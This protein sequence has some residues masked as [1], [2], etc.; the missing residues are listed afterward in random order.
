MTNKVYPKTFMWLFIGLALTF[1]TG[2]LV[3][4]N[5]DMIRGVVANW[6]LL[7][8]IELG[9][10]IFLGARITKM[11]YL[12]AIITYLLYSFLTGLTFSV[13]FVAFTISSIM[14]IFAVTAI[15]FLIFAAIGYFTKLDITKWSSMLLMALLGLIIMIIIN[16]FF[17]NSTLDLII[18]C[19]G[20]LIFV[21]YTAYDIQKIKQMEGYI[22]EDKLP[23]Y[24][25]FQ[26]YLDFINIFVYLLRIFG[27]SSD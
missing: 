19:I 1:L 17:S 22:S 25:A 6:Y 16:L 21:V 20:V 9:V 27:R 15:L 8:F 18:S 12:T 23:V 24:G 10:V 26:L 14:S 13:L 11:N 4:N 5:T 7:V 3:S 2:F